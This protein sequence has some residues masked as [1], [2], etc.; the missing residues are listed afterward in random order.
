MSPLWQSVRNQTLQQV[1]ACTVEPSVWDLGGEKLYLGA[2]PQQ[3]K[4]Q[5]ILQKLL[6]NFLQTSPRVQHRA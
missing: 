5:K 3:I 2:L 4:G 6:Q 1:M